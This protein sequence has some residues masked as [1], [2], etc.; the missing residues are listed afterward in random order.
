[1]IKRTKRGW[2]IAVAIVAVCVVVIFIST[3]YYRIAWERFFEVEYVG[4]GDLPGIE[5]DE[6]E[7][8]NISGQTVRLVSMVVELKPIG[9]WAHKPIEGQFLVATS[10]APGESDKIKIYD[11]MID[12]LVEREGENPS[13]YYSGYDIVGFE[14]D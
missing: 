6:Y 2:L 7:V 13:Y 1:M 9:G 10:L 4:A 8:K 14:W 11:Y 3:N 12:N 5:Y